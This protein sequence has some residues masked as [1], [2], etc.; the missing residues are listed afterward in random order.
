MKWPH[1]IDKQAFYWKFCTEKP[2]EILL[3]AQNVD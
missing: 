3:K 2:N 1:F